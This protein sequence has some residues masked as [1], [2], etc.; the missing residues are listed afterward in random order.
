MVRH[1]GGL[2]SRKEVV[3]R[4]YTCRGHCS[5]LVNAGLEIRRAWFE[6]VED[7]LTIGLGARVRLRGRVRGH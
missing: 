1:I 5:Q 4:A 2:G 6:G 3:I 7:T